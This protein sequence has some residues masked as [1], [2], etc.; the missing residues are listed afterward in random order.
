MSYRFID[1][2]EEALK[3][4]LADKYT[5][6]VHIHTLS[7]RPLVGATTAKSIVGNKDNL[8][9]WYADQAAVAALKCD[10]Q[11][12]EAEYE[13]AQAITDPKEKRK[14]KQELDD[15]YPDYAEAR[16]AAILYRDGKAKEGT[17]RHGVLEKYV[18]DCIALNEGKPTAAA[19]ETEED[20]QEFIRWS[21]D[22]VEK[23]LF[24]E[25]YCYSEKLWTG[26]IA[27]VGFLLK[28]GRRIVG[29]HKSGKEA[30]KDQ[31]IQTALYD[32]MLAENG[33]LTKDGEK[34]FDWELADGYMIFPFGSKPFTPVFQKPEEYLQAAVEVVHLYRLLEVND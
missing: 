2:L 21:V 10:P 26:G 1:D 31:F 18:A 13:A 9:Q 8:F 4:G 14:A 23:F 6:K 7:G 29:D 11:D 30:Y 20:I 12:I 15:K 33:G 3:L 22:N 32:L 5:R 24:T 17:L 28:D 16:R 19:D 27:D 25:T 34:L